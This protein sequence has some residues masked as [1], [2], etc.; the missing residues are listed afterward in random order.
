[1]RRL[2]TILLV[3]VVMTMSVGCDQ[4]TKDFARD[5]LQDGAPLTLVDDLVHLVYAENPGIAFGIGS[6]LSGQVRFWLFTVGI[7][8][9]IVAIGAV[10][11]HR[12]EQGPVFLAGITLLMAGGLSNLIDRMMH[13]GHVID[14]MVLNIGVMRTVVFNVADV[15]VCIGAVVLVFSTFLASPR[16][17]RPARAEEIESALGLGGE[18]RL[19]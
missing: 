6:D 18:E 5:R 8:F 4:L 16:R 17:S 3:I 9:V 13:D 15:L 7:I 1:M 2:S 11:Y 12:R 19:G 14:F 10:A